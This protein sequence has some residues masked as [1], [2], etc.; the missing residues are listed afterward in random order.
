MKNHKLRNH[1]VR[2]IAE[3]GEIP[4]VFIEPIKII[5]PI[6]NKYLNELKFFTYGIER[7]IDKLVEN[8]NIL[9]PILF[10]FNYNE[11]NHYADSFYSEIKKMIDLNEIDAEKYAISC[12]NHCYEC[13]KNLDFFLR[14]FYERVAKR[15]KRGEIVH[16]DFLLIAKNIDFKIKNGVWFINSTLTNYLYLLIVD[17]FA[18]SKD[19]NKR[20]EV[21]VKKYELLN[22]YFEKEQSKIIDNKENFTPFQILMLEHYQQGKIKFLSDK[23]PKFRELS[24]EWGGSMERFKSGFFRVTDYLEILE[25]KGVNELRAKKINPFIKEV[26]ELQKYFLSMDDTET[27]T[28]I[29][30]DLSKLRAIELI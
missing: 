21:Y 18:K 7:S 3:R 28:K 8:P 20:V 12:F 29:K 25:K 23:E 30:S 11:F 9:E 19:K 16:D 6:L 5:Y 14:N 26:E 27:A 1:I 22:E 4:K 24:K 2:G 15:A 13:D 10:Y 17:N